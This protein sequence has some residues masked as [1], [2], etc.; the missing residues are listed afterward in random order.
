MS[1]AVKPFLSMA[2]VTLAL[3]GCG[4]GGPLGNPPDVSNPPPQA[5]GQHLSFAY[6]QKCVNPVFLAPLP[7]KVNGSTQ[8]NTCAASGCHA[9]ATG[10]GGALR[11]LAEA[12][13]VDLAN[14]GNTPDGVR[15]TDMYKN[16]YSAQ[17][18]VVVGSPED[19][20]LVAKPTLHNVLHG[21]GLVFPDDN[22]PLLAL[23]K[24]WI[25]HPLPQGQDEF[26]A[27]ASGLF[28]P[29]GECNTQ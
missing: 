29:S 16:F 5:S 20:R 3:A 11:I 2:T 9:S 7:A 18:E 13:T 26:G 27:A 25:T 28:G 12:Q 22:D 14:P 4:G 19:S 17:G 6:F 15:A 21:G 1:H 24:Y 8:V 23:F 10:T